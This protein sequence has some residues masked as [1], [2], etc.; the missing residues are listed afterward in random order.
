[1]PSLPKNI[2]TAMYMFSDCF[3]GQG[4][5]LA[6]LSY[7]YWCTSGLFFPFLLLPNG[8]FRR[9]VNVVIFLTYLMGM[10]DDSLSL[11]RKTRVDWHWVE[12]LA[13]YW[14]CS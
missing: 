9:G 5:T 6:F 1:M 14:K 7:V 2:S 10:L 8:V 3:A 12:G 11:Q 13:C 4:Y